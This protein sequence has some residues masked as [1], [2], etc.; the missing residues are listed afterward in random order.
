MHHHVIVVTVVAAELMLH[1]KM[2][3]LIVCLVLHVLRENVL[4]GL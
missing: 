3:K 2:K 1:T 4:P